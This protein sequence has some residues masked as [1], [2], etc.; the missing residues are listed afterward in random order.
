MHNAQTTR[1]QYGEGVWSRT[2]RHQ[3]LLAPAELNLLAGSYPRSCELPKCVC[4]LNGLR[5]TNMCR[6]QNCD[7]QVSSANNDERHWRMGGGVVTRVVTYRK[8]AVNDDCYIT[9]NL[10]YNGNLKCMS[11][12]NIKSIVCSIV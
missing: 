9:Y 1:L 5:C 2:Q 7:N 10:P 11:K 6:L 4:L 8:P 12:I 3:V